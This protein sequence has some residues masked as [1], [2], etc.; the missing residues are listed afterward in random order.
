MQNKVMFWFYY[1]KTTRF[2]YVRTSQKEIQLVAL[3]DVI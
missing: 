2:G 1:D 3:G